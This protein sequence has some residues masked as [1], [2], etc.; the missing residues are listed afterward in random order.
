M[1]LRNLLI[2]I[3]LAFAFLFGSFG[4]AISLQGNRGVDNYFIFG[5]AGECMLFL[6]SAMGVSLRES[7]G[8]LLVLRTFYLLGIGIA[9]MGFYLAKIVLGGDDTDWTEFYLP[10]ILLIFAS[11]IL[12]G[13][14]FF[15]N[16]SKLKEEF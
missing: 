7:W 5:F 2:I 11:V 8:R 10:F 4:Y 6:I 16:S 9:A 13:L 3:L 15:V 14:I 12:V 1:S